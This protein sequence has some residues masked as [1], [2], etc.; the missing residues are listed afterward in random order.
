MHDRKASVVA[1]HAVGW[2]GE[3]IRERDKGSHVRARRSHATTLRGRGTDVFCFWYATYHFKS[4]AVFPS[5][6]SATSTSSFPT[7]QSC[8]TATQPRLCVGEGGPTLFLLPHAISTCACGKT[9]EARCCARYVSCRQTHE[10][11]Q[12]GVK[13]TDP[14]SSR[15]D[16]NRGG[17]SRPM[18]VS[19]LLFADPVRQKLQDFFKEATS[20]RAYPVRFDKRSAASVQQQCRNLQRSIAARDVKRCQAT[21]SLLINRI[22][23]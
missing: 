23:R 5:A 18:H 13:V 2:A 1:T 17:S 16:G 4:N 7:T 15:A 3:D 8:I 21:T 14:W 19:A 22:A 20:C 6:P 9:T 10:K 11:I 12:Q